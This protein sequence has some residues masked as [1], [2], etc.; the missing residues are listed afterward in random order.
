M[1][2]QPIISIVT[3]VRNSAGVIDKCIESVIAQNIPGLEYI[4]IDGASTDGTLEIIKSYGVAISV[5]VS[6]PDNGL[7]DAMNKGL[8]IARGK[9]IHFLNA[10][11]CYASSNALKLLLP[12]LDLNAVCHGQM[13]YVE[14][15]GKSRVLG[16]RFTRK[17]ELQASR[18]PQP[19]MFV[20][21][22]MYDA[23]GLFETEYI[24]AADYDMV[25]RLTNSFDTKFI[26]QQVTI[27]HSGGL[28]YQRPEIAF[29]ESRVVAIKHGQ[30]LMNAWANYILKMLK[31]KLKYLVRAIT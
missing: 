30:S 5:C 9:F 16:E 13:I 3:V 4:I 28:S 31:W 6:E 17:R 20:P 11:D 21:R 18:M 27:M 24:V 12:Q 14:A 25:L 2:D 23:V 22:H 10:D 15:S 8:R 19:V 7:Y 1:S 26:E 29:K